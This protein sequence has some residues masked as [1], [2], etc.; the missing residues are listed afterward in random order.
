[1][2]W[3]GISLGDYSDLHMLQGGTLTSSRHQDEI[4][5]PYGLACAIGDGFMQM[6]DKYSPSSCHPF[7][8]ISREVGFGNN[9]L[10]SSILMSKFYR[11]HLRLPRVA[12]GVQSSHPGAVH[13]LE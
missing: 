13:Y 5:G 8:R 2:V 1:M 9:G 11:A 4:L 12:V 6:D 7:Q 10:S 3:D